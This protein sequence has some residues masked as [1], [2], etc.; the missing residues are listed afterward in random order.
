VVPGLGKV[1]QALLAILDEVDAMSKK[2]QDIVAAGQRVCDTAEF[3]TILTE[4]AAGF[5]SDN[6][7]ILNFQVLK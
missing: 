1:S 2:A 7:K 6:A 5:Q 3:L 4:N